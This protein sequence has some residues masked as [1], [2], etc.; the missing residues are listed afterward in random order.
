MYLLLSVLL[1]W[2]YRGYSPFSI[3]YIYNLELFYKKT[4]K[5]S[6]VTPTMGVEK[7]QDVYSVTF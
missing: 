3:K 7:K 2:G 6:F 1:T 4:N 5:S